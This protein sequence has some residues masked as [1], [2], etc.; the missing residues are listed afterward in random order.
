M[1]EVAISTISCFNLIISQVACQER[2]HYT[3]FAA[4][5]KPLVT[6]EVAMLR[7]VEQLDS[8]MEKISKMISDPYRSLDNCEDVLSLISQ[9]DERFGMVSATPP[10][11]PGSTLGSRTASLRSVRFLIYPSSPTDSIFICSPGFLLLS[12]TL[13]GK[14]PGLRVSALSHRLL[15][16]RE[17]E[18]GAGGEGGDEEQAVLD[19][20]NLQP[21]L[22]I[23]LARHLLYKVPGPI[24]PPED[25]GGSDVLQGLHN[26]G[27]PPPPLLHHKAESEPLPDRPSPPLLSPPHRKAAPPSEASSAPP[28]LL[29]RSALR[30]A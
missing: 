19:H 20:I 18:L 8:V 29:L 10:G 27:L 5:L 14:Q 30:P 11:S 13:S 28:L 4:C 23:H 3:T 2:S 26:W 15:L 12:S 9:S 25:S 1:R 7:E 21:G 17:A 6:E 16:I 24:E 22:G